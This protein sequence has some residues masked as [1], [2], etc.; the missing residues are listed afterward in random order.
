M[1]TTAVDLTKLSGE[2]LHKLLHFLKAERFAL[3]FSTP[4][5]RK[6]EL[7]SVHEK[8]QKVR[9]EINKRKNFES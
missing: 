6:E 3:T 8:I 9:A 4:V 7:I 1:N 2:Q 5:G